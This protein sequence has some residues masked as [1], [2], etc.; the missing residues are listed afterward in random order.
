MEKISSTTR[1][2]EDIDKLHIEADV[3]RN[4]ENEI[5]G[6]NNGVVNDTDISKSAWFSIS[7]D[8]NLNIGGIDMS[9]PDTAATYTDAIVSFY[10]AVKAE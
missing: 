1:Y 2:A 6:I 8:G 5:T 4:H 9:Q 3:Y 7:K 10:K